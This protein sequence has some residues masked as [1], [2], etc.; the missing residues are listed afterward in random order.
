M[1]YRELLHLQEPA[2]SSLTSILRLVENLSLP[3]TQLHPVFCSINWFMVPG[4]ENEAFIREQ[5]G[6]NVHFVK[7]DVSK[8]E[9]VKNMVQT[10]IDKFGSLHHHLHAHPTHQ[11]EWRQRG[12]LTIKDANIILQDRQPAHISLI[13]SSSIFLLF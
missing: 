12:D 3:N 13:H 9:D 5:L 10:A 6:G 4:L 8:E 2:W 11:R 1:P 7:A